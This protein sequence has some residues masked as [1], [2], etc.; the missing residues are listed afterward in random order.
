M[1]WAERQ[2]ENN[3]SKEEIKARLRQEQEILDRIDNVRRL[4]QMETTLLTG[5]GIH[6]YCGYQMVTRDGEAIS[7][8]LLDEL[9]EEIQMQLLSITALCYGASPDIGEP[10]AILEWNTSGATGEHPADRFHDV[11]DE[12]LTWNA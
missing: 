9:R 6:Q 2:G 5:T 1:C 8:R 4:I 10:M 12:C 11:W 3:M 7:R